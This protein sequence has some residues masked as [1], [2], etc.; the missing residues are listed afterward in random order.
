M[1][2]LRFAVVCIGW[3]TTF[4]ALRIGVLE[5]PAFLFSA[6]RQI[7]AGLILGAIMFA[8]KKAPLPGKS[9]LI[10]QA[11]GGFLL[12]TIGNGLV[13]WAEIYVPSGI[14][15][16]ICSMVPIWVIILN[17]V[18]AKRGKANFSNHHGINYWP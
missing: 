12:I 6:L 13:G 14:A 15:A 16:I 3:G 17:L 7:S 11:I 8:W 9:A 1:H 2:I 4:L 10:N 5:F 18:V